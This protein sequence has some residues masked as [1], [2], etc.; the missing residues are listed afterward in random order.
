MFHVTLERLD[1]AR[2]NTLRHND[3][4]GHGLAAAS[5]AGFPV[6]VQAARDLH[7][8]GYQRDGDDIQFG[9]RLLSRAGLHLPAR[10]FLHQNEDG[11]EMLSIVV[12]TRKRR[13]LL[14]DPANVFFVRVCQN[15]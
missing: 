1:R 7:V 4:N 15:H 12:Y 8:D 11:E 3:C 9:P 10:V 5:P 6:V 13:A 2:S 14:V